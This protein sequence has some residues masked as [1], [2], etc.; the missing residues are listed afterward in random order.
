MEPRRAGHHHRDH[1]ELPREDQEAGKGHDQLAG[2][3]GNHAFQGHQQEDAHVAAL[4]DE[5][6]YYSNRGLQSVP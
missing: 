5:P 6:A 1:A 4:I 3:G 2:D